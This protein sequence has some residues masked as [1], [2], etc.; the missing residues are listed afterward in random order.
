[1]RVG[2]IQCGRHRYPA[3]AY[4]NSDCTLDAR[5]HGWSRSVDGK[6]LRYYIVAEK[7][8]ICTRSRKLSNLK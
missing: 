2:H 6:R 1:M 7:L 8:R 4:Y 5:F 3:T